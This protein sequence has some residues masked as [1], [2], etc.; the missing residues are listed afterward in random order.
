MSDIPRHPAVYSNVLLPYFAE[1]S[2]GNR[3]ILDPFAGTGKIGLLKTMG[4]DA[5]IHANDIESEWLK[6]NIYHCDKVFFQDAEF[7]DSGMVY[8]T[9]ITSPTYGNRMADHFKASEPNGRLT[10]THCLGHDLN[11]ENTGRMHFGTK[12]CEK[13]HRIYAHLYDILDD[14]GMFILNCSDF[15]KKGETQ[16]VVDWTSGD[17]ES[18]GFVLERRIDVPT[19]RMRFGAHRDV[20]VSKEAILVFRKGKI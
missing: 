19:P 6:P 11:E 5:E 9:I 3:T 10:Y 17:M 20:R 16:H 8:D 18:V 7:F 13:H 15:I 14:H 1:L 12:Y 4:V 2:K